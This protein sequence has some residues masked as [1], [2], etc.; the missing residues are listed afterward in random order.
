MNWLDKLE[1][2]VRKIAIPNLMLLIV[3]CTATVFVADLIMPFQIS[4]YMTLDRSLILQG[5]VWRLISFVFVPSF[6]VNLSNAIFLVFILYIYYLFGSALEQ[7]WGTAKF[8]IYYFTGILGAIAA[9]MIT[10]QGT[11][12]YLNLSIVFA[13]AM[14]NPDYP[15]NLFFFIPVKIKYLAL[16]SGA[17]TLF[18]FI[19]GGIS[20]KVAIL[21]SLLNFLLFFGGDFFRRMKHKWKFRKQRKYYR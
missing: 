7:Q 14:L 20:D 6:A 9:A 5:Q 18:G 19:T 4:S 1:S 3:M 12:A 15:I 10:G 8:N 17:V 21:F 11:N 13:F 2:K 16:L